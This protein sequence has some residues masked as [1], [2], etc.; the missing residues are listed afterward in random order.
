MIISRKR[1]KVKMQAG[2]YSMFSTKK[3]TP[4]SKGGGMF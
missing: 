4:Q 3:L 1:I 2:G